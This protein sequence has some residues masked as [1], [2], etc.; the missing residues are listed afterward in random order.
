ML[1][2][3]IRHCIERRLAAIVVT[4]LVAAYGAY[5][6]LRTPVEAYPDV[7]NVQVE[8]VAQ[9][10]GLAPEGRS[11]RSPSRSSAPTATPA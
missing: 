6:Y 9:V 7:T 8:V 3:I 11:A 10:A 2:Q 5:A 4:L 1:Q